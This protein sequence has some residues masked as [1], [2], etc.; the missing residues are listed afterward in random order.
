MSAV[1]SLKAAR[2]AGVELALDGDDLVLKASS[3]P[4]AAVL[5]ALSSHKAEIVAL[6]RPGHDGWSAEDWQ[7]YFDERAGIA[8]F[9][10]RLPRA[11]AEAQAFACCVVKWLNRNSERSPAGRCLDC[12]GRDHAHDP[13]LPYGV[14]PTGH[15]W[16]HSRCW[17]A[18]YE[19]RKAKAAAALA[20]MGITASI[21]RGIEQELRCAH[22]SADVALKPHA[23]EHQGAEANLCRTSS[24]DDNCG[25]HARWPH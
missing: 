5:D 8:E 23:T 13:L 4:P 20:V 24:R 16:L 19:T 1:A 25:Q 10:A 6:L 7:V 22:L 3:A 11:Q 18:W 14:E 9:D 15:A 21:G 12:G 17:P 2:A